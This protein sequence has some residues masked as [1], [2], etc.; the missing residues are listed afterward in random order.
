[1]V[2]EADS[3]CLGQCLKTRSH[4][5]QLCSEVPLFSWAVPRVRAEED[6]SG[7]A[8]RELLHTGPCSGVSVWSERLAKDLH[9]RP[10][11]KKQK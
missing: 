4:G 10:E 11:R 5:S 2:S 3:N 6:A 8:S 7:R 9:S 1:M